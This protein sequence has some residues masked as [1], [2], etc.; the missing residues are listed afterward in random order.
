MKSQI[1]ALADSS[2]VTRA[3]VART[4]GPRNLEGISS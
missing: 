3:V 1:A 4:A 2:D